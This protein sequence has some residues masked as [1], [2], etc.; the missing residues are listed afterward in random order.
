MTKQ[1]LQ[2]FTLEKTAEWD[3]IVRSF[4]K[5]DVYYLSGYVK[6]FYQ[7]GDGQPLLF[8][9]NNGNTRGMNVVMKRLVHDDSHGVIYYDFS[10]PY[11]Y[12]GW[13]LEGEEIHLVLDEYEEWCLQNNIVSEFVR[14]HP[15]LRNYKACSERYVTDFIGQ[16]VAMDLKTPETIWESISSKNRNVIRK[17]IKNGVKIYN[18]RCEKIYEVFKAIYDNTMDRDHADKYYYFDTVFYL[19]LLEDLPEN[20]QIFYAQIPEG[21]IIAAAIILT[22]NRFMNY[23]LSGSL[24]EY[25]NLAAT[26]LLLYK[27]A[28]WGAAN[29]CRTLYLGGGVGGLNDS[30]FKFKKSFYKGELQEFYVGKK[31]FNVEIY[32]WLVSM[33]KGQIK[34][35]DYFPLYRG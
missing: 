1:N 23:H 32:Q 27:A 9:Y 34:N 28:L 8:Y 5:Y 26:N 6:G 29:G 11:G 4:E 31:V 16:T 3:E 33:R 12:G 7:H 35:N 22:A 19:S 20:A 14:F 17:A 13:L 21:K 2:V 10:T 30:L 15:M 25:G 18:G 24:R